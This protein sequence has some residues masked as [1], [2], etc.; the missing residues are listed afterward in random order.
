MSSTSDKSFLSSISAVVILAGGYSQRMGFPKLLLPFNESET[1]VEQIVKVYHEIT[2]TIV[3]VVNNEV[4][5]KWLSFFNTRL[6][7]VCIIPNLNPPYGRTHSIQLGL[8][9]AKANNVFIQNCDNPF[10]K[11][12]LLAEMLKAAPADGYVSPRVNKKGGHP[13]LLCGTAINAIMDAPNE[14]TLKDILSRQKR[15]DYPTDD[16]D[17]LINIDTA[18]SY[19]MHFPEHRQKVFS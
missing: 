3:L 17:I 13:V 1:F 18:E 5:Q 12:E 4:Y 14:S 10:V 15:I 9:K 8:E 19:F 6:P 7:G 16:A 2:H 11:K